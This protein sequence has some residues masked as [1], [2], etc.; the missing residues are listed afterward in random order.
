M[1]VTGPPFTH[2]TTADVLVIGGG[3]TGLAAAALL[4]LHEVR[5][6]LV[7]RHPGTSQH[8]KAR[9]VNART[10]EIYRALGIEQQVL[11]AG[12]PNGGF[13]IADTLAAEHEAWIPPPSDENSA[14]LS[15]CPSW[16]C[17]QQRIEPILRNRACELGADL[18]FGHTAHDVTDDA[19]GV[20]AKVG[21]RTLTARYLVAADGSRSSV[22]DTLNL[23]WTGE[24]VPGTGV[25]ALFRA[26]LSPALKG[27]RADALL[28]RSAG[29]FLFARG[30]ADDRTW[31]LGT[32]LTDG[33]DTG[34]LEVQTCESI[35][36]ATGLPGL[37]P[38][39]D[40]IATWKT[41]AYVATHLRSGRIF[42]VGDAA[43]VM[44]PYGGFGGNTGVQD[45]HALAWRLAR[46]C[47]GDETWLNSYGP[48][49]LPV[50]RR[51]VDQALLRSR[52]TPGAPPPPDQIDAT[53]LI[54]GFH[55]GTGGVE[56]PANPSGDPG[57]RAAHV[58]LSD[59]CSSLDL[60]DP[61]NFTNVEIPE[62]EVVAE[63]LLRWQQVYRGGAIVRPDGVLSTC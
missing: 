63:H 42:L 1:S 20:A 61:T 14:D 4:A 2:S 18:R 12:E 10:M 28:A 59:G 57:T 40:D 5:V 39:I 41:G 29:A 52:K 43:H 7:E 21:D 38:V 8:P 60:L 30:N 31:Q 9:L 36:A 16:S 23:R 53:T 3:L 19:N 55:Y 11:D 34:D 45:A 32:H 44:P 54:L 13:A 17:D 22:R 51:T 26:D 49:R 50:A 25:S 37:E 62:N 56:D 6:T 47:R 15:P 24:P 48:E 46:A 27:R 33:S 58:R 35:R